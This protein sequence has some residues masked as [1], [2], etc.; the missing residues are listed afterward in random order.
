MKGLIETHHN[1]IAASASAALRLLEG[2]DAKYVGVLYDPGNMVHEGYE[3]HLLGMQMLGDYLA[4]IHM[5]NAIWVNDAETEAGDVKWRVE[6]APVEKGIVDWQQVI[7]DLKSVGYDGYIG[8]EDFSSQYDTATAL[9]HNYK[10]LE[11]WTK[12]S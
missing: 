9:C 6:W 8:I 10:W 12:N 4:H 2:L 1:T 3:N 5:K 7:L 11:Q